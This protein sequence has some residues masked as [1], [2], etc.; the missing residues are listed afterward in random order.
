M[1]I[2]LPPE[3]AESLAA[4]LARQGFPAERTGDG[5]LDVLFPG[6]TGIFAAAAELDLWEADDGGSCDALVV[7]EA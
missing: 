6:S 5:E 4:H 2:Q 7:V 3:L 1:R